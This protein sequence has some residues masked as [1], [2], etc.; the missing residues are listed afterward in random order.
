VT[1]SGQA[2]LE[3]YGSICNE[4]EANEVFEIAK[5]KWENMCFPSSI[6]SFVS[7]AEG[8]QEQEQA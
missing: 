8:F 6:P 2:A 5:E 3:E 1:S 7:Y 4:S